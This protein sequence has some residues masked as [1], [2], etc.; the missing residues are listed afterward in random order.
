MKKAAVLAATVVLCLVFVA[1]VMASVNGEY[2]GYPIVKLVING[3]TVKSDV[4]AIIMGNRTMVPIAIVSETLGCNVGWNP[5]T[6]TVTIS[7]K[8]STAANTGKK[9]AWY[10]PEERK[11]YLPTK[12][13]DGFL[14]VTLEDTYFICDFAP[15][16]K[17]LIMMAKIKNPTSKY[18]MASYGFK[19]AVEPND[20][21]G[22]G[23]FLGIRIKETK[24]GYIPPNSTV[25]AFVKVR[26]PSD[27]IITKIEAPGGYNI[28]EGCTEK[29]PP[30]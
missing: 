9:E 5:E 26:F 29:A 2:N 25:Q 6:Y 28:L 24:N 13:S 16:R 4:P 23:G 11:L 7:D 19:A 3:K 21:R 20:G 17:E 18:E 8:K 1:V 22:A 30:N 12:N 15:E 10:S 27:L 14:E